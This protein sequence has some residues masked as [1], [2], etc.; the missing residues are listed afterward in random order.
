MFLV[1]IDRVDESVT[2]IHFVGML[3]GSCFKVVP[4]LQ[5]L[6][7]FPHYLSSCILYENTSGRSLNGP[8]SMDSGSQTHSVC[9]NLK[10][11]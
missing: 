2:F 7:F 8:I 5:K 10:N 6:V 3:V 4:P 9:E 11:V 1:I